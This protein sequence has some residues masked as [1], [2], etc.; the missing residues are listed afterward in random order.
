MLYM[1]RDRTQTMKNRS[2]ESQRKE[3][4]HLTL[5]IKESDGLREAGH[6]AMALAQLYLKKYVSLF[7]F[8]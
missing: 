3:T 8:V 7:F 5:W 6:T 2:T 1:N 4:A